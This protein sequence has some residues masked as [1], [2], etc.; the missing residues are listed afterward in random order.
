M[1]PE[2]IS[3]KLMTGYTV[4]DPYEIAAKAAKEKKEKEAQRLEEQKKNNTEYLNNMFGGMTTTCNN[5]WNTKYAINDI[6]SLQ[7]HLSC[8]PNIDSSVCSRVAALKAQQPILLAKLKEFETNRDK[9]DSVNLESAVA[10][11]KRLDQSV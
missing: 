6:E 10:K 1:A 7:F 5:Y 3:S 11:D 2:G 9:R 8:N 4:T